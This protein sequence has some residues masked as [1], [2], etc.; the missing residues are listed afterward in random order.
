M[1]ILTRMGFGRVEDWMKLS[2]EGLSG[3]LPADKFTLKFT[4]FRPCPRCEVT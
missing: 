3:Q 1:N 4:Y 2:V